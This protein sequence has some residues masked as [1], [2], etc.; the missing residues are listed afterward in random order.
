MR[1][2]VGRPFLMLQE[3]QCLEAHVTDV[4]Q[5]YGYCRQRS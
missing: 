5:K 4:A 3:G 2:C 1:G